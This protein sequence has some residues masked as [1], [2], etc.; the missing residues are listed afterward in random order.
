MPTSKEMRSILKK[1]DELYLHTEPE[2]INK[3]ELTQIFATD[4][5]LHMP[6]SLPP[7]KG[8]DNLF[9][10]CLN[11]AKL[12][13]HYDLE[14]KEPIIT[15]NRAA[16]FMSA[17]LKELATDEFMGF[18]AIQITEFNEDCKIS[19]ITVYIDLE[20]ME[21]GVNEETIQKMFGSD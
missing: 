19:N 21:H 14:M 6:Y 15:G 13:E 17:T 18:E 9:E 10:R 20:V 2:N 3:K 4:I 8:V 1:Y 16:T 7:C 11:E 5:E 12:F